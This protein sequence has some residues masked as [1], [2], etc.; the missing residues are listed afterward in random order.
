MSATEALIAGQFWL[1]VFAM[2]SINFF[3]RDLTI[4]QRTYPPEVESQ[5]CLNVILNMLTYVMS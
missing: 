3:Q 5:L 2:S 4:L 1:G